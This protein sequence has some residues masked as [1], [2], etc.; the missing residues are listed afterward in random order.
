MKL[1]TPY[2]ITDEWS[3]QFATDNREESLTQQSDLNESDINIIMERFG[4]TGQLPKVNIDAM[5]G[6]FSEAGDYQN[7]MNMVN[8][9]NEAFA[10]VPAKV[11]KEFDND[12][13]RFIAYV[14]DPKNA[15]QVEKWGLTNPKA[16]K[17]TT[18]ADIAQLLT[19]KEPANGKAN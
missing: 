5:Y 3:K 17:E 2:T 9:A 6:D 8:A 10:M 18:L 14:E 11:R 7:A 12:A 16:P 15:E 4:Q 13:A 19:P 1:Q